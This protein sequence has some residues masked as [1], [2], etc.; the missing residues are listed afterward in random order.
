M[1][2]GLCFAHFLH[3]T[4]K[5]IAIHLI[6]G[7]PDC[8]RLARPRE[9]MASHRAAVLTDQPY[10]DPNPLPSTVPHVDELGTTSA[11]LKSASFFIGQHC[12]AVNGES[13]KREAC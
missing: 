2:W 9:I 4:D 3:H 10:S 13:Y 6:S 11:P 8:I 1:H 7:H 5:L 12:K